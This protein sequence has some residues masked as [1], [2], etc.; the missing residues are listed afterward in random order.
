MKRVRW[1][2]LRRYS[3][4]ENNLNPTLSLEQ[5]ETKFVDLLL[6]GTVISRKI[7]DEWC[8][9]ESMGG[10]TNERVS[11]GF[12]GELSRTRCAIVLCVVD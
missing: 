2:N 8:I 3:I 10:E 4:D 1:T 9:K 12:R 5:V 11:S 7:D 6:G